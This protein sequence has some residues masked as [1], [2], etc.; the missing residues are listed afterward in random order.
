MKR[1]NS[2]VCTAAIMLIFGTAVSYVP[3]N[4]AR[5]VHYLLIL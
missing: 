1:M 2:L 4:T 5:D 3:R